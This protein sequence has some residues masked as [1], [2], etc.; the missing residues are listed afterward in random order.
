[1]SAPRP[2]RT[3][4]SFRHTAAVVALWLAA[5][6]IF[7]VVAP[8]S[9]VTPTDKIKNWW[10]YDPKMWRDGWPAH[11]RLVDEHS[12]WHDNHPHANQSKHETFHRQLLREHRALHFHKAVDKDSGQATWYDASG[13]P[14]ACGD[15]LHGMYLAHRTWPCGTLVSVRAHGKYILARVEDRGPYGDGRI[16]DL[17]PKAFRQLADLD[18]G[19]IDVHI[20]RL[21]G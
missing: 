18:T 2:A 10:Q 19:V 8:A 20:T 9:G 1:M 7:G 11:P 3:P 12:R 5:M 14:G 16:V 21:K 4:Q 13:S 17:S 15:G 6:T